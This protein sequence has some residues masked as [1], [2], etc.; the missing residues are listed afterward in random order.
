MVAL[1]LNILTPNSVQ[2]CV[3]ITGVTVALVTLSQLIGGDIFMVS[4]VATWIAL[5]T[6]A[7]NRYIK[8]G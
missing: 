8:R 2:L 5:A 3:R 7:V 1:P 6:I 4:A